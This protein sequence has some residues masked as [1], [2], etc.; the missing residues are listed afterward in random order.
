VYLSDTYL[1]T[2]HDRS[3]VGK[4]IFSA[5]SGSTMYVSW[6]ILYNE[7]QNCISFY[8]KEHADCSY[9]KT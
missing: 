7:D 3:K 9:V 5:L 6:N 4:F 2:S 1:P 8:K